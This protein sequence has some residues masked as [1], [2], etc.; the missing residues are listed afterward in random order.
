[1]TDDDLGDDEGS[2][3]YRRDPDWDMDQL[4]TKQRDDA[5]AIVQHPIRDTVEDEGGNEQVV[6]TMG[7]SVNSPTPKGIV[8]IQNTA[9]DSP[10][11]E[12]FVAFDADLI[13]DL[14][15]ALQDMY[16]RHEDGEEMTCPCCGHTF[17][18]PEEFDTDEYGYICPRC[19]YLL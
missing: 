4:A 14:I 17:D 9:A 12:R 16:E 8:T 13:P 10:L 18:F 6:E 5:A 1:M 15:E 2:E 7:L 19:E 11:T 3:D